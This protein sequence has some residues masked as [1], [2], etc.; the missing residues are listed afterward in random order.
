VF[1]IASVC[2]PLLG[3]AFTD[4]LTWR[5]CFYINLPFGAITIVAV[6]FFFKPP[7]RRALSR[8]PF[9]ERA[10]RIDWLGLLFLAPSVICLLLALQWGGATYPWSDGR[11]IALF[12]VFGVLFLVFAAIEYKRGEAATVPPRLITQRTVAAGSW[13][14]FCNGAAFLI[15][16]IYIPLWHQ[17]VHG[18]SAVG[19]GIR[20]LPLV[21]GLVL[22]VI[23][24]GALVTIMGYCKF[25]LAPRLP[26]ATCANDRWPD[27]PF[28]I[29]S[30][31]IAP[32]G[33]GLLTT[34]TVNTSFSEWFGYQALAG[35]G[36]GLGM[37]QPMLAVQAALP[38][39]DVPVATSII[40]FMQTLGGA[41]FLSVGQSVFQTR[42]VGN[43]ARVVPPA[44]F[45][46]SEILQIG[47]TDM[48]T[49][50][51]PAILP[52]V[53]VAFNDALTRAWTV[54]VC[55]SCLTVFG[56]LAMEWRSV[57]EKSKGPVEEVEKG[58]GG[59]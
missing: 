39:A 54:S 32:I 14:A 5:W 46:P 36:V 57:K 4:K 55:M 34:F 27:V 31:I 3:G 24:T 11:V 44:L 56:S 15:I 49:R 2:G 52:A 7:E 48:R 8:I 45:D 25:F 22:M 10:L 19:S 47:A 16:I 59:E 13:Y 17:V 40:I 9:I 30:S 42:L 43:L 1:G 33:E 20:L 41:I 6:F 12:V 29:L 28:M 38:V 53:L 58:P 23:L 26:F 18:V 51:P 37:Q 50:V 35:I 21:I